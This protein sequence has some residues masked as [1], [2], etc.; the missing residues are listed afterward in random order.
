MK[1]FSILILAG[2]PLVFPWELRWAPD[3]KS[4]SEKG[5]Y[6]YNKGTTDVTTDPGGKSPACLDFRYQAGNRRAKEPAPGYL[7]WHPNEGGNTGCCLHVYGNSNGGINHYCRRLEGGERRVGQ[8][9]DGKKKLVFLNSNE[10]IG[11]YRVMG[12]KKKKE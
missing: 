10:G 5:H 12:C 1:F 8:F 2:A 7:E 3:K 4:I 9:C 11:S 6:Y